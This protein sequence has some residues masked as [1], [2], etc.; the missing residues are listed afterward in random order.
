MREKYT[1]TSSNKQT[2]KTRKLVHE[3]PEAHSWTNLCPTLGAF[4]EGEPL[5]GD[6]QGPEEGF[7][8]K[9]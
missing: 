3:D 4:I 9:V 5:S 7:Q 1:F 6:L 8:E 2:N